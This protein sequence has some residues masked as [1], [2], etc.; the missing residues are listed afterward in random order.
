MW[1]CQR[2]VYEASCSFYGALISRSTFYKSTHEAPLRSL[3]A[4]YTFLDILAL[5][6]HGLGSEDSVFT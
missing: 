6:E 3:R 1:G 5:K 2:T 4:V